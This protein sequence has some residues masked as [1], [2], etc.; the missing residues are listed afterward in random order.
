MSPILKPF[1]KFRKAGYLRNCTI[2]SKLLLGNGEL[3]SLA[4][5]SLKELFK[6]ESL[7]L[8]GASP[9]GGGL[10]EYLA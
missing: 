3:A 2:L 10:T 8:E 4:Y 6:I 7:L 9:P 1:I 5:G